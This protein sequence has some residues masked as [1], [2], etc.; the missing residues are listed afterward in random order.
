MRSSAGP[1]KSEPST[2]PPGGRAYR[3]SP[4]LAVHLDTLQQQKER[5][6]RPEQ[7]QQSLEMPSAAFCVSPV[8]S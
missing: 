4:G 7:Q 2:R 5:Q 1:I 8:L 3:G 6:P